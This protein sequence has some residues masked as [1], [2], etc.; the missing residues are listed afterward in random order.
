MMKSVLVVA[1]MLVMV[2]CSSSDDAAVTPACTLEGTYDNT[3]TIDPTSEV[4]CTSLTASGKNTITV[5]RSGTGY[6]VGITGLAGTCTATATEACKL[7][8]KCDLTVASPTTAATTGTYQAVF[9]FTATGLTGSA[10]IS[11]PPNTTFPTGCSFRGTS[12][13]TRL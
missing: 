10:A 6:D 2:G 7:Q 9:T 3:A 4:G 11:L 5:T 8:T 13:A 1:M 12:S